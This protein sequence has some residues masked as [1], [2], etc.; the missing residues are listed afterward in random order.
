ML[1][2]FSFYAKFKISYVTEHMCIALLRE[3]A[4]YYSQHFPCREIVFH[5]SFAVK[6]YWVNTFHVSGRGAHWPPGK[7]GRK[8]GG[9]LCVKNYS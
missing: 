1:L 4:E 8:R 5:M 9:A 7:N 3:S 2:R 6:K